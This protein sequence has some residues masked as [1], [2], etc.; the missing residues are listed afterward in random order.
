MGRATR[1]PPEPLGC[2]IPRVQ[3]LLYLGRYADGWLATEPERVYEVIG[4]EDNRVRCQLIRAEVASQIGDGVSA[5]QSLELAT[6]WIL[7]SGSVEHLCLYHLTRARL[8]ASTREFQEAQQAVDEGLRLA[9]QCGLTLELVRLL[10]LQAEIA[11]CCSQ[12]HAA[13]ASARESGASR[14]PPPVSSPGAPRRP[15]I[16]W[17]AR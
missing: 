12:A 2:V 7:H 10:N 14:R 5:R 1:L 3:I 16:C 8:S 9:R 15:A 11:L 13:E 4:W 17:A 6:P